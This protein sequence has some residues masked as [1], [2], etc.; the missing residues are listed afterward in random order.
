MVQEVSVTDEASKVSERLAAALAVTPPEDAVEVIIE[1]RVP[2]ESPD[3]LPGSRAER[4]AARR[5]A[6]EEWSAS[7]TEHLRSVG[8]ELVDKAWL[9]STLKGIVRA[10]TVPELA[11]DD[12]VERID[13]STRLVAD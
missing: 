2:V 11:E 5:A 9:N 1:L 13:S 4:I 7:V 12:K 10:H 3:A 8:G 6:F